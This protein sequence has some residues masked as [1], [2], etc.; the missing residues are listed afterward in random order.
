[1]VSVLPKDGPNISGEERQYQIGDIL[2]LNCTS[3]K[4]HPASTLQWYINDEF[5]SIEFFW[6][7]KALHSLQSTYC[8]YK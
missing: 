2:S 4:S 6:F 3:G 7:M 5:V 1:M 8:H